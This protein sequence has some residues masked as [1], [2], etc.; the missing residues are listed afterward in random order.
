MPPVPGESAIRPLAPRAPSENSPRVEA[1]TKSLVSPKG[2]GVIAGALVLV[3]IL[4]ACP[5]VFPKKTNE[6]QDR[7]TKLSFR[8]NRPKQTN[9]VLA[10]HKRSSQ[11]GLQFYNWLVVGNL[12]FACLLI[13]NCASAH[14]LLICSS[15]QPAN[16]SVWA[17]LNQDFE[18]SS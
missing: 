13:G 10:K 3:N 8:V 15:K 4:S 16:H 17:E 9:I 6:K 7:T 2:H 14:P 1:W 11:K 18:E 5:H 12:H